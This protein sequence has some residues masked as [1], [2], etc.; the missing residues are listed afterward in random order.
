MTEIVPK[1]WTE[2]ILLT[3]YLSQKYRVLVM[4]V[5]SV[6][7]SFLYLIGDLDDPV[8]VW[9]KLANLFRNKM[10]ANSKV[11]KKKKKKNICTLHFSSCQKIF[12]SYSGKENTK[13]QNE[14]LRRNVL[15][16]KQK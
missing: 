15:H 12:G 2:V 14:K 16:D 7:L 13:E 10:W 3:K 9:K 5:L 11:Y 6:E 8:V 4:I 1:S